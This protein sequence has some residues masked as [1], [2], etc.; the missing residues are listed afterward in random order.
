MMQERVDRAF[1]NSPGAALMVGVVGPEDDIW[2][3]PSGYRTALALKGEAR[4]T[5]DGQTVGLLQGDV[6]QMMGGERAT[7][8][9][10]GSLFYVAALPA[11]TGTALW[12]AGLIQQ[13]RSFPVRMEQ[14]MENWM[15]H[16]ISQLKAT[17][18]DKLFEAWL[19]I[20]RFVIHL[21]RAAV[22]RDTMGKNDLMERAKQEIHNICCQKD[23]DIMA[24]IAM[25]GMK[26]E[27][28]RKQF[29]RVTGVSP[30]Q[31]LLICR[32]QQAGHMLQDGIS[33]HETAEKVGYRD[34]FVFSR[35]FKRQMGIAPSHWCRSNPKTRQTCEEDRDIGG[36]NLNMS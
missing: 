24:V 16:L 6:F 8:T 13:A 35:Q 5:T 30:W 34:P 1:P 9:G 23:P 25:L 18:E 15:P 19:S 2:G 14:Y 4:L 22:I 3:D 11:S 31:Y 7:L 17:P 12:E 29:K 36:D 32:F 27:T 28:F 26:A 10:E 20:Q 33:V 21:H